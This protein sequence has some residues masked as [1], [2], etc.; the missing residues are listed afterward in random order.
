M[1]TIDVTTDQ[2]TL[3]FLAL[4]DAIDDLTPLMQDI[5]VYLVESAQNN[6][7]TGT[8]PDGTSYAPRSNATEAAYARSDPV[9]VPGGGPL[10]LTG[11][12]KNT[13]A[14]SAGSDY[15]DWG[16]NAIQAAVMQFG[17]AQGSFGARIGK[18]KN[19]RDFFMTIPWGD[20][21]ARPFLGIGPEDETNILDIITG[22]LE[23][24]VRP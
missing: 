6:I 22:Y 9:K 2:I 3:A 12:M 19:G 4:G 5:G 20:I 11:T 16:S 14:Y 10:W 23:E 18:D 8:A 1:I 17:A 7:A 15:V 21:P 24:A 13:L